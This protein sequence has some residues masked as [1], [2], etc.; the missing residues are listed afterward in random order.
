MNKLL[1]GKVLNKSKRLSSQTIGGLL[2]LSP[3]LKK[4]FFKP[5]Q[6]NLEVT[7]VCN[8]NCI[9]C[10]NQY[11]ERQRGIMSTEV[12]K[13]AIDDFVHIGG[14]ALCFGAGIGEPLLDPKL[15]QKINYARQFGNIIHLGFYTNGILLSKFDSLEI[16]TSGVSEINVSL[17][18]LDSQTYKKVFRV[19]KFQ[20]V[21]GNIISL[22]GVNSSLKN[23]VRLSIELRAGQISK[24]NLDKSLFLKLKSLVDEINFNFYFHD[25]NGRIIQKELLPTMRLRRL[26]KKKSMCVMPYEFGPSI[27]W[28]GKVT[29]CNCQNLVEDENL[30]LGNILDNSLIV[31]Y[32]SDKMKNFRER[33]FEGKVP[34]ICRECTVYN[35]LNT[36]RRIEIRKKI[37][38][39]YY[40]FLN[41]E[42]FRKKTD[43]KKSRF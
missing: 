10:A 40:A 15:F 39:S 24:K 21:I 41:S 7:N 35:D 19:D 26:I 38:D 6:L 37:K 23:P 11:M 1:L 5:L 2:P 32:Q 12:F 14:G 20:Q 28:N 29:A 9:F 34:D 16:L 17:G 8:A 3:L 36:L 4:L 42:Y 22:A 18:G 25:W 30:L 27:L 33:F 31:L 43:S 13:K